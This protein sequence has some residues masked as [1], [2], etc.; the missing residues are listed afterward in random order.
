MA[1]RTTVEVDTSGAHDEVIA[2]YR[3]ALARKA[4]LPWAGCEFVPVR[5]GPTWQTTKSG[6]WLLPE[7][8]VGWDVLAWCGTE[9][10]LDRDTPWRFTLEQARF[11]LHWYAVDPAGAWL[12]R[13][14]VLQRLK[15]WGKDPVIACLAY[16][17]A[18]GPCRVAYM[19][20]DTPVA[21][22]SPAAW[23]QLPAVSLEQTKNTMRLMPGLI[24]PEARSHYGVQVGKELIHA[25]DG[26]RL[27]QAVTSSP[28]TLEGGRPTA[29]YP[30]ETHHWLSNNEG[31]EMAAVIERN[32]TKSADGA[33]RRLAVTNA[34]EPSE[35]S[36]AQQDREAWETAT[37]G[38]S[39]TT[40]ILYDSLEAPPEAPLSAEA[41]PEVVRAI[42]GDSVWLTVDRI[43]ASILDTRNPPSRSRRF[44]YN[45]I[46]AS[47]DA[48]IVPQNFDERARP[49]LEVLPTDELVL[50]FDGS[51]SDDATGL[52][53]C[54]LSDGLVVTAGMWQ[55]PPGERGDAW[56]SP[57]M[58]IDAT[59][60]AFMESH[61][62]VAF[63]ADPSHTLDDVTQERYWDTLIDEWHRRWKDRLRIWAVPGKSGHSIMWDMT[64]PAR[65]AEFTAAA[66]RCVA[67]IDPG[68]DLIHDGDRRLRIHT[69]N[70]RRYPGRY[71]VSLWKGHRESPRKIDLAVCMV[72]ARM[73]R[74]LVLNSLAAEKRTGIVHL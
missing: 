22:D 72:G 36:V 51:K 7:A 43:V 56:L 12:H 14:G 28:R 30:N 5:V 16:A 70:A 31:H 17:E 20:G 32:A 60:T 73:V 4:V 58:E 24:T 68:G 19:D 15:G 34:Y 40:G 13:D 61:E 39:L 37:A 46:T 10:Q 6:H 52:V 18:L 25:L 54:R 53:A 33:A 23:V 42:R 49:D 35:Q 21:T 57:R 67:D 71:G 1:R 3:K 62:V 64:S 47:E 27:I 2:W 41:A 65:A 44:W 48:W 69:L 11:V 45:Q 50:F 55:K 63:F 8:T 59:V 9:L 74:R 66:E 38:E 26:E 29:V